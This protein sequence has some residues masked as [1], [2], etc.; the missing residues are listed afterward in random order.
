MCSILFNENE[1]YIKETKMPDKYTADVLVEVALKIRDARD[2][3]RKEADTKI[4]KFDEQFEIVN[5]RLQEILKNA[6]AT[7]LKTPHGTVYSQVKNRYSTTNWD[8]MYNFIQEHQV[9]ELLERRLHQ[10]NMKLYL[11]ENP[12]VM[13]AGLNV[14]SKYTVVIRR[15]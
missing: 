6:G 2:K 5:Q 10:G 15:K 14:D 11:E 4:A 1:Q 12:D 3:I 13:P 9:Y 8:A 7:S